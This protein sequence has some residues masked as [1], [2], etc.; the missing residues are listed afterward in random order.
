MKLKNHYAWLCVFWVISTIC[1]SISCAVNFVDGKLA[2]GLIFLILSVAFAFVSGTLLE[3]AFT[4]HQHNKTC[5]WLHDLAKELA[6][7][8]ME[9]IKPF[10]EFE[11]K[12][13]IGE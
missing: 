6:K 2:V 13:D 9:N 3:K 4:I 1:D 12:N 8:Q 10:D 7:E 11:S 5:D